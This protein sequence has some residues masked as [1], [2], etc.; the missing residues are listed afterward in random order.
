MEGRTDSV[1]LN[2]AFSQKTKTIS[3]PLF[4]FKHSVLL[5]SQ[6]GKGGTD[7]GLKKGFHLSSGSDFLNSPLPAL[8]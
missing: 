7:I 6:L 1:R 5:S 4:W 3:P 8:W 2:S